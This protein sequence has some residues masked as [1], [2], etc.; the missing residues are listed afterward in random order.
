MPCNSRAREVVRCKIEGNLQLRRAYL[1]CRM[2]RGN[3][4]P[5]SVSVIR[6]LD[7]AA[8]AKNLMVFASGTTH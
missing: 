2:V 8:N 6:F 3:Y 1:A 4:T 7:D 5:G